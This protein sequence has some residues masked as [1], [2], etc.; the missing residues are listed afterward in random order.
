MFV[1]YMKK[2]ALETWPYLHHLFLLPFK[3]LLVTLYLKGCA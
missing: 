1:F 3:L 2:I